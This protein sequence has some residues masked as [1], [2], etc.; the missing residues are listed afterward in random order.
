MTKHYTITEEE[1]ERR[2]EAMRRL[3]E[4]YTPAELGRRGAAKRRQKAE[5]NREMRKRLKEAEKI[6]RQQGLDTA[7]ITA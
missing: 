7:K 5:E 4:Q 1:K 2:R 3:H 6:I